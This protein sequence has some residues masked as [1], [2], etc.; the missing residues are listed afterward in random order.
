MISNPLRVSQS[1]QLKDF[2][3]TFILILYTKRNPP[4]P[5]TFLFEPDNPWF[6]CPAL[7]YKTVKVTAGP[8]KYRAAEKAAKD[9]RARLWKNY[10]A[11]VSNIADK[12]ENS[13]F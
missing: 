2:L 10:K 5:L 9:R 8:E 3:R 7:S 1:I 11:P 4:P 6:C 13:T 12:V